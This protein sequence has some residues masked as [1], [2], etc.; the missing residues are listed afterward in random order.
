MELL[1]HKLLDRKLADDT[2]LRAPM[3][4]HVVDIEMYHQLILVFQ[5]ADTSSSTNCQ[6]LVSSAY[7]H[8]AE[9]QFIVITTHL[10]LQVQRQ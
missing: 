7:C 3:C 6:F 4:S 9:S 10:C 5:V 8:I 1:H 2:F